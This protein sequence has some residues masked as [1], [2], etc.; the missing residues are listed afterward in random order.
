M[1]AIIKFLTRDDGPTAVEYAIML[2]MI[3]LV[4]I[5]AIQSV[6]SQTNA[7]FERSNTQ[8]EAATTP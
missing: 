8:I 7:L 6:G 4:C 5:G 2:A 3:V 1:Q